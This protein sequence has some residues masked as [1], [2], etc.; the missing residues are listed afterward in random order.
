MLPRLRSCLPL[1]IVFALGLSLLPA[2]AQPQTAAAPVQTAPPPPPKPARPTPPRRLPQRLSGVDA[3]RAGSF[4]FWLRTQGPKD[5]LKV[6]FSCKLDRKRLIVGIVNTP[7]DRERRGA[8]KYSVHVLDLSLDPPPARLLRSNQL[9]G[10]VVIVRPGGGMSLVFGEVTIVKG[11]AYRGYRAI[12][13][14]TGKVQTFFDL[15]MEP[16]GSLRHRPRHGAGADL[17]LLRGGA[18]RSRRRRPLWRRRAARGRRLQGGQEREASRD[19]HRRAQ[20]IRAVQVA[21]R[22]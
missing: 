12:D 1:A 2:Q 9:E 10:A 20:W 22:G 15:P 3:G 21:Y 14:A 5:Q 18:G 19:F 11:L 7:P 16:T 8:P 6:Q 4:E 17:D 13:I